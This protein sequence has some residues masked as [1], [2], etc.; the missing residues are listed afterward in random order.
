MDDLTL[1]GLVEEMDSLR[2]LNSL[3]V[4][5]E[6]KNFRPEGTIFR[7]VYNKDER[8]FEFAELDEVDDGITDIMYPEGGAGKITT[9]RTW[10]GWFC[11]FSRE[12]LCLGIGYGKS[13][14]HVCN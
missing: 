10:D 2:Y 12:D 13:D 8:D 9:I 14:K 7:L 3:R 11:S 6:K 4:L 1:V 5:L